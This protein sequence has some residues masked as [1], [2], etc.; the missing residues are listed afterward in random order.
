MDLSN[1]RLYVLS[2]PSGGG[3]STVIRE[4]IKRNPDIG[5]SVSVTTRPRRKGE[6]NGEDYYFIDDISVPSLSMADT[7]NS[8]RGYRAGRTR[9]R[10]H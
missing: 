1:G 6:K 3:K 8:T 7:G 2:S 5:Y 10:T 4:L 9:D